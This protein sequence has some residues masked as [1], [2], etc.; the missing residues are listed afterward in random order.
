MAATT[1]TTPPA[2]PA[3]TITAD[4]S[5]VIIIIPAEGG[6]CRIDQPSARGEGREV[7]SCAPQSIGCLLARLDADPTAGGDYKWLDLLSTS[8]PGV[9]VTMKRGATTLLLSF[10]QRVKTVNQRIGGVNRP[11][12][13]H[14]PPTVWLQHFTAAERLTR[15]YLW[16]SPTRVASV[17]DTVGVIASPFGNVFSPAGNLCWGNVVTSV[18][19]AHDPLACDN[20]F[21]GTDFNDHLVLYNLFE[22]PATPG[23]VFPDFRSWA[24]FMA[25]PAALTL[26]A[27]L[28]LRWA[29]GHSQPFATALR[30][31]MRREE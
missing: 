17:A 8:T 31:A 9:A 16:C 4:A 30:A 2:A 20:L 29:N 13:F 3:R 19:K 25:S 12:S 1:T 27:P 22:N 24:A 11:L 6:V 5:D 18:L 26:T 7:F 10:P 23:V 15:S 28:S 21:W 14:L